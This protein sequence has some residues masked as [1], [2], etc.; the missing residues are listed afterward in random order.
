MT[1]AQAPTSGGE[2]L[3]VFDGALQTLAL[4]LAVAAI[5]MPRQVVVWQDPDMSLRVAPAPLQGGA[6]LSITLTHL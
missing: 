3:S 2:A 4:G 6:G 1:A 5:V